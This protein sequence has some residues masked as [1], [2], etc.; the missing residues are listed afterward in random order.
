MP[1]ALLEVVD[2]QLGHFVA[3]AHKQA[4]GTGALG[5]VYP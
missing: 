4:G 1:F 5:H 2:R 3:A